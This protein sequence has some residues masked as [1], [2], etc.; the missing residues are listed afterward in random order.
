[1]LIMLKYS[2]ILIFHK[3]EI[4]LYSY[5]QKTLTTVLQKLQTSHKITKSLNNVLFDL[6]LKSES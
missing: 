5:S 4:K 1:M 6:G 2:L 3:K